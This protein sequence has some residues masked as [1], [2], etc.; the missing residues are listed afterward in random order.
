MLQKTEMKLISRKKCLK[1]I[2]NLVE[3]VMCAEAEQGGGKGGCQV[4]GPAFLVS[5]TTRLQPE[6]RQEWLSRKFKA[7]ELGG[8]FNL[9]VFNLNI[10]KVSQVR[11]WL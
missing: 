10:R 1:Q 3:G 7:K 9:G 8:N 11:S 4:K 6:R 2:P 5:F